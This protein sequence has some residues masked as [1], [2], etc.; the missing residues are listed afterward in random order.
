VSPPEVPQP[1]AVTKEQA[2]TNLM[3]WFMAG[4]DA[5][6]RANVRKRHLSGKLAAAATHVNFFSGKILLH[7]PIGPLPD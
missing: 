5:E 7:S 3:K 2:K 1:I 6:K 4:P